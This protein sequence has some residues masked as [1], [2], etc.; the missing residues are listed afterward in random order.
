MD[1]GW[2]GRRERTTFDSWFELGFRSLD[3]EADGIESK[4]EMGPLLECSGGGEVG[5]EEETRKR[6]SLFEGGIE[7]RD[8]DVDELLRLG[9]GRTLAIATVR[10]RKR[11]SVPGLKTSSDVVTELSEVPGPLLLIRVV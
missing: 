11:R 2:D 7:A 9:L 3:L 8:A 6:K 5:S 1:D 10:R 4:E